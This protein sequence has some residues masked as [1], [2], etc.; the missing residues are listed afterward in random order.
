MHA[1]KDAKVV[2][3]ILFSTKFFSDNLIGH[4]R[5]AEGP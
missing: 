2:Y 3:W 1:T 5:K 4:A